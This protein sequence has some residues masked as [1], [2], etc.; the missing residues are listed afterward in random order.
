[1]D[2]AAPSPCTLAALRTSSASG[3]RRRRTLAMS[4]HTTPTGEV[5]TPMRRGQRGID[6]LRRSSNSPSAASFARS[7]S[8]RA[9][10]SPAPAAVIDST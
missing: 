9:W 8:Y 4:R 6:R 2:G 5:T 10:R 7:A 3:Y 1:M